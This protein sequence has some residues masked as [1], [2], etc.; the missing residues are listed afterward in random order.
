MKFVIVF[1]T[2]FLS[3]ISLIG[4]ES[5]I[6]LS[7]KNT[8]LYD[9]LTSIEEQSDYTFLYFHKDVKNVVIESAEI[10]EKD[11]NKILKLLL[12]DTDLKYRINDKVIV[13]NKRTDKKNQLEII[14]K[15]LVKGTIIDEYGN[16]LPGVTVVEKG[17]KT[18]IVSDIN[19]KYEIPIVQHNTVYFS[20]IGKKS[21][22]IKVNSDT[23]LNV[24]MKDIIYDIEEVFVTGYETQ[25]KKN[26]SGSIVHVNSD[27]IEQSPTEA[28]EKAVQGRVAGVRFIP[29][30]G[31]PGS[32]IAAKI[33]GVG[34]INAANSPLFI[35][36]GV[37]INTADNNAILPASNALA[38]LNNDDIESIDI[39][40]DGAT[41]SIYGSQAANGVIIITTKKGKSGKVNVKA[42]LSTG[43][44]KIV[45][46][47][48][49]LN[50]PE[51][52]ELTLL[53][54]KN[55]FGEESN[56]Y[57]DIL[58]NFIARGWGEDGYSDAP[59]TDWQDAVFRTGLTKNYSISASGGSKESRYYI[60]TD[61]QDI[62][63][64]VIN[65]DFKKYSFR[66][67]HSS[68][69]NKRVYFST[70]INYSS[71]RQNG[72]MDESSFAN[73]NRSATLIVPVNPVY[74]SDGS[75]F[76]NLLGTYN[77]NVVQN[78]D[79]SF[80]RGTNNRLTARLSFKFKILD[81]LVLK[82]LFA[83]DYTE[84]K[85]KLFYDP[86][87]LDGSVV[88]G[89]IAVSNIREKNFQTDHLLVYNKTF[90][91]TGRLNAILGFSYRKNVLTHNDAQ[92]TGI[93]S[94]DFT[95]LSQ[96]AR[97]EPPHETYF[98][99]RITG[100]FSKIKYIHKDR[101]IV[102]ATIRRDG[103]NRF[104]KNKQ[105]GLFPAIST[106]WRISSE[107]FMDKLDFIDELKIRAS[108]GITGNS[109]IES[110]INMQRF[111]GK[112]DY[113]EKPGLQPDLELGNEDIEWEEN[114]T[115]NL[116]LDISVL[117]RRLNLELDFFKRTTKNLV[118]ARDL[119]FTTGHQVIWQNSGEVVNRGIEAVLNTKNI[120]NKDY[121]WT[122]SF[123]IA[124]NHNEITA[125]QP[126][127]NRIGDAYKV[128]EAID[129][130]Y[131][132][133]YAGVNPDNGRP[134]WYDKDGNTTYQPKAEDRVWID[135][136][137]PKFYGGL[138]NDIRIGRFSLSC[139]FDFQYGAR[140]LNTNKFFLARGGQTADRNQLQSV[141]DN[142]WKEPG[143]ITWVPK[144]VYGGVYDGVATKR[145]YSASTLLYEKTDFIKLRTLSLQYNLP[146]ELGYKIHAEK[147]TLFVNAYN[148]WT[149]S[150]YTGFDPEFTDQDNGVY[151]PSKTIVAGINVSF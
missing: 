112:G 75:Y 148:L 118:L 27:E 115:I 24:V 109:F 92:G 50:G 130:A 40:K 116:G 47:L 117:N 39:L 82:S 38:G 81:N 59:T 49:V 137:H 126:G 124:F 64:V 37:Q 103:S 93:P 41:A 88:N 84:L 70:N 73:P 138:V 113:M 145:F 46:K 100:I 52:A 96:T 151:P 133:V 13:I 128:G 14:R 150:S 71:F 102:N 83:Y 30:T 11:I 105:F 66:I 25:K 28:F 97:P 140:I 1:L 90:D 69:L 147:V 108:Y 104:G 95:L 149:H 56:T 101:Y 62:K 61:Y 18:G 6:K 60:S 110:Y 35:I 127:V 2:A 125:L 54:Y 79:Y 42:K 4:Q 55:R 36:D 111:V 29:K 99:W 139:V 15:F 91:D 143:D 85:E 32:S 131:T 48:N 87:T 10:N 142:Y 141:Y 58:A 76:T 77:H 68:K 17:T 123:N 33:R 129:A 34:S 107:D 122:S 80:L 19:G 9:I 94:P 51:W 74:N 132:Y 136:P 16:P 43:V 144:P 57:Q 146:M 119:P 26:I 121:T 44:S 98:P 7:I 135:S 5:E 3:G 67:N 45:K 78:S 106:A 53:N 12:K 63:G 134:M 8:P 120:N 23:T 114:H 31:S 21:I 20:F 65:T 86:R 72:A 22:E 89:R